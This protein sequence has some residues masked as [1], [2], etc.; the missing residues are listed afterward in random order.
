M[1]LIS[2]SLLVGALF[3]GADETDLNK[4]DLAK[5]Q[6]D[7]AAVEMYRDGHPLTADNAQAY[8]RTVEGDTYTMSRYRKVAG[9]G[10]L[11]LDASKSP[12]EIDA[13]PALPGKKVVV[14]GIYEWDG[15]KLKILFGSPDGERPTS[16]KVPSPGTPGSYTVW[17]KEK[18]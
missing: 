15:D 1:R 14:K 9:K 13:S 16:L 5:M 10:T 18:K 8:F 4:K 7:W 11:K 12:K 6:G 17:E 2:C 3:L